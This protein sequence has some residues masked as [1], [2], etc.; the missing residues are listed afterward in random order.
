MKNSVVSVLFLV[1][2]ISFCKAQITLY[3]MTQNG[4]DSSAG[5]L[6]RFNVT[7]GTDTVL[8]SFGAGTDGTLPTGSLLL[9]G[10]GLLYGLTSTGGAGNRGI[11]FS[12]NIGTGAYRNIHDFGYGTDG[13]TPHGTLIQSG[14]GL[15]YGMTEAG[16]SNSAGTIFT[17]NPYND[18]VT[19][20]YNWGSVV[21]QGSLPFGSLVEAYDSVMYGLSLRGGYHGSGTLFDFNTIENTDTVLY[22]FGGDTDSQ[23]PYGSVVLSNGWIYGM[24][25]YGG[26]NNTGTIFGYYYSDTFFTDTLLYHFGPASGTD[27]QNPYGSLLVNGSNLYGMTQN[28]GANG[29]GTIFSFNLSNE[30]ETVLHSFGGANDGSVPYGSLMQAS[31]SLLYGMTPA[32]GMYGGGTIFSYNISTNAET[33]L[34]S[35]AGVTDGESPKGDLIEV[36]GIPAVT[37]IVQTAEA[38]GKV[39]VSPNPF[40]TAASFNLQLE[41]AGKVTIRIYNQLGQ[42]IEQPFNAGCNAGH[43]II[44]WNSSAVFAT[45]TCYAKIETPDGT[46]V[47]KLVCIK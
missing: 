19:V 37:G 4:G 6:F 9:A 26:N 29:A 3:G 35:F 40:S 33:P 46:T 27:A 41:Q 24:S 39:S 28:G 47:L 13:Q 11:I 31:N 20:V 14:N 42:F 16:G 44:N 5:T 15:L 25:R 18:S 45:G 23:N 2:I 30:T 17:Y 1:C 10:N 22:S 38:S 12:Y 43:N 36:D 21:Q 8:H 34:Y 7:T 32:G